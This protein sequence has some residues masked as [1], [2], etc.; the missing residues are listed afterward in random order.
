MGH[1]KKQLQSP[2][3]CSGYDARPAPLASCAVPHDL[4]SPGWQML[5]QHLQTPAGGG[6]YLQPLRGTV[7]MGTPPAAGRNSAS[8][9]GRSMLPGCRDQ[10]T[11]PPHRFPAA[12]NVADGQGLGRNAIGKL[13]AGGVGRRRV[14]RLLQKGPEGGEIC[15]LCELLLESCLPPPRRSSGSR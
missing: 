1:V 15:D 13:V 5:L 7:L 14:V 3:M 2:F 4:I 12:N 9:S 8:A 6:R 10:T 11:G